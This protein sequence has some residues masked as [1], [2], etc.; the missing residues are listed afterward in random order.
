MIDLIDQNITNVGYSA[1]E[2][3]KC[4]KELDCDFYNI[5]ENNSTSIEELNHEYSYPI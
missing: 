3:I 1:K 5:N 4:I 2:L